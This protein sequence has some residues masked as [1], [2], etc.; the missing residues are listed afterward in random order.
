MRVFFLVKQDFFF[1]QWQ[2]CC[3]FPFFFSQSSSKGKGSSFLEF[4][5]AVTGS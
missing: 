4:K 3:F 1:S 2:S 5:E